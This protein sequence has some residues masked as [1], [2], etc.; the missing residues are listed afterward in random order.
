MGTQKTILIGVILAIALPAHAQENPIGGAKLNKAALQFADG[1]S[2]F[3]KDLPGRGLAEHDFLY[4]G[5]AKD[6]RIYIV[7]KGQIVW[8]YDD[9]AGKGEISDA[10][11]LSDGKIVIA[12]QYAV[13]VIAADGKVLWN[14]DAPKGS[15][16]HTAQ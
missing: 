2:M 5:E 12:H 6:R 3:P 10:V 11:R 4:A 15:E 16:I 8:T 14:L 7:K 13:K 1:K 9:P